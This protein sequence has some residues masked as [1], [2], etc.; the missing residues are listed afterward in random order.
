MLGDNTG[1]NISP[2]NPAFCELTGM[3]WAW[4][5][6]LTSDYLGFMHYRRFL[7]FNPE[8]NRMNDTVHG[9][10]VDHF[11]D[12]FLD[13]FGLTENRIEEVL[14]TCDG[15]IT[16]PINFHE[17]GIKS[18]EAQYRSAPHHRIK[19]FRLAEKIVSELYPNDAVFFKKMA[20]GATLYPCNIFVFKRALFLE[21]CEWIFP[22]LRE[23]H[24]RIDT[25]GYSSQ[26]K[27]AVGFLAERLFTVFLLKK[28]AQEPQLRFEELRLVIVKETS[29]APMGPKR[30]TTDLPITSVVASS[31]RG[32][33]PHLAALIHS[34]FDNANENSF[35][36]F[37]VLDGGLTADERVLLSRI[38]SS[39]GQDGRITF[40]DMSRQFLSINAHSYFTR[41][42]FYRLM[43]PEL[44]IE[45]DRVLFIDTD[46]IVLTD[47]SELYN[48]DLKDNSIAAVY[49]L[50]MRT[51]TAKGVPS[52]A[53]AGGK[54]ASI[55]LYEHLG[56]GKSYDE[57]FQ[58]GTILFDLT[59]MRQKG[60]ASSLK[61]DLSNNAFWFLDQD[62]LNKHLL[63]DVMF[64]DNKWNSL[65]LEDDSLNYLKE[66]ELKIYEDSIKSPYII[67]F[68][69]QHKP[70]INNIHPLGH[71]YWY[72]L[73][74]THWYE[75]ILSKYL[76]QSA[77][78]F[79]S[80]TPQNS[81]KN[82]NPSL[83]WR[84][85]RR[86]WATMPSAVQRRI[87]PLATRISQAI[88]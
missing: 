33:L 18:V 81:M 12:E 2:L 40:I 60:Y 56:M 11:E 8:I 54:P 73:R 83:L 31:D 47:L 72:Y 70:W 79:S 63:K 41:S 4:K 85:M 3:Y 50:V 87:H 28:K 65:Y 24:E 74:K 71:H 58:A 80:L 66:D 9:V 22:I 46:M 37:I 35:I 32:Y 64:I 55:Y 21:Y 27:R 38:P 76:N 51:F 49:D 16:K 52:I 5:N 53:Q 17:L 86:T 43:L 77:S 7:D 48:I 14:L 20:K 42:T 68:A 25:T 57:Y 82:D 23:L 61:Q 36:D 10:L 69:G 19:D 26:S 13:D 67:H 45:Y 6:D 78:L 34:V 29:P 15:V 44:L 88:R 39:Y 1:D 62:V 84:I 30:P 59:K 75:I